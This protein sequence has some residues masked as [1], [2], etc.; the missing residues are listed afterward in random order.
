VPQERTVDRDP[1]FVGAPGAGDF[2]SPLVRFLTC[3][4]IAVHVHPPQ[5]PDRNAFVER[6]HGTYERECLRVYQ[7]ATL[8]RAREVTAAFRDHDHDERPNQARSCGNRP[9]RS[10]FPDLPP[11]PPVPGVVDPDA[12]LRLVDGR[13]YGRQVQANGTVAVEHERYHVG[14][15]LGGQ[16]VALAV[17][18]SEQALVVHHGGAAVKRLPLRGLYG[19]PLPFDRYVDRMTQEARIHTHRQRSRWTRAAA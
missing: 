9:P 4:G 6:D 16:R 8:E 3:L 11:C 10:A 12:W 15:R 18:A 14:R 13:R 1:R 19:E 5:R 2:P 17:V 7:P